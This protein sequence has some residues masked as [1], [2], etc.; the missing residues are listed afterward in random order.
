L[1]VRIEVFIRD[2]VLKVLQR[3]GSLQ[4]IQGEYGADW[5]EA[6]RFPIICGR[7]SFEGTKMREGDQRTPRGEYYICYINDKSKFTLF[8]GLSYPNKEDAQRGLEA[9]LIDEKDFGRISSAID[10]K[11]RPP[12]NTPLGGEVGIHGGGIDRDGTRG[13]IALKDEDVLILGKYINKKNTDKE[14][15]IPA[16]IPVFI[17]F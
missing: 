10:K 9:N 14:R 12:W 17:Y 5:A 8:F 16:K 13:C 6:E 1:E 2:K 7:N 11:E 3:G 4:G 15:G